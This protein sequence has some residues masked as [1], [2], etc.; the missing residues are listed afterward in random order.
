MRPPPAAFFFVNGL[1]YPTELSFRTSGRGVRNLLLS[2]E[3]ESRSLS[4]L[5]DDNSCEIKGLEDRPLDHLAAMQRTHRPFR[6]LSSV[7]RR[8]GH[9]RLYQR[10]GRRPATIYPALSG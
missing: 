6:I 9:Q 4:A 10:V 1:L 2:T 7:R 3:R 8:R 5:R